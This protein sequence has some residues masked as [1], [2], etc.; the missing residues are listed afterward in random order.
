MALSRLRTKIFKTCHLCVLCVLVLIAVL[1]WH[2]AVQDGAVEHLVPVRRDSADTCITIMPE[3]PRVRVGYTAQLVCI[4]TGASFTRFDPP[5]TLSPTLHSSIRVSSLPGGAVMI[6]EPV[7]RGHAGLYTCH[8]QGVALELMHVSVE[9]AVEIDDKGNVVSE[10]PQQISTSQSP[11]H[12]PSSSATLS[13]HITT[14]TSSQEETASSSSNTPSVHNNWKTSP[15]NP[16][17][18][19]PS[20]SQSPA[21]INIT[22]SSHLPPIKSQGHSLSLPLNS[23]GHSETL[24][25]S[26]GHSQSPPINSQGHSETLINS[27]G[28]S[29]SPPINSQGHSESP[30]NSQGH[31]QL[32][33]I[34]S[35]EKSDVPPTSSSQSPPTN[36]RDSSQSPPANNRGSPP[37]NSQKKSVVPPTSS[38]QSPPTDNRGSPPI[39]Q[40]QSVV[41]P[42]SSSQSPPTTN[43]ASPKSSTNNRGHPQLNSQGH[44]KLPPMEVRN[45]SQRPNPNLNITTSNN[46][47]QSSQFS[48]GSHVAR[49]KMNAPSLPHP[50]PYAVRRKRR[51]MQSE[52]QVS[53]QWNLLPIQDTLK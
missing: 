12:P 9:L 7:E 2:R 53:M 19:N 36:S 48:P 42:T 24:I 39:S 14:L 1:L 38:S 33:P 5:A 27:Q 47:R 8:A 51:H 49:D 37:I 35:Q 22:G 18:S 3:A 10:Q 52:E 13:S 40:G 30:I 29:Q 25:N 43:Q 26:Q 34:N 31:S 4:V 11:S 6:V 46:N 44:I 17:T 21:L 15:L 23:Q 32:P 41:P 16:V 50:N 45:S 28:H 20:Q